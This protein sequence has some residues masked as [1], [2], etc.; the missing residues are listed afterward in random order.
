MLGSDIFN[1]FPNGKI[2]L[3]AKSIINNFSTCHRT[4]FFKITDDNLSF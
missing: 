3:R 2:Y 1:M 4:D